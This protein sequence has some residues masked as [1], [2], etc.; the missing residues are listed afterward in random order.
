MYIYMYYK[1]YTCIGERVSLYKS[2]RT[3]FEWIEDSNSNIWSICDLPLWVVSSDP[4]EDA[5][6]ASISVQTLLHHGCLF[7]LPF[8]SS[9]N[10]TVAAYLDRGK[11]WFAG[12]F[13]AT[14]FKMFT[15]EYVKLYP[16]RIYLIHFDEYVFISKSSSISWCPIYDDKSKSSWIASISEYVFHHD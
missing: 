1:L 2:V 6:C 3:E 11:A 4:L 5:M 10:H 13:P 9:K 7:D 16:F 15:A 12:S 8:C 14:M